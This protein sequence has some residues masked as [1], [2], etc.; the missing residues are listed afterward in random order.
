MEERRG[1][2]WGKRSVFLFVDLLKRVDKE[3]RPYQSGGDTDRSLTGQQE[4][5]RRDSGEGRTSTPSLRIG[6]D[7]R[8]G[9]MVRVEMRVRTTT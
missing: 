8:E 3:K 5:H 9:R 2:T 6:Q 4:L 7:P 1:D